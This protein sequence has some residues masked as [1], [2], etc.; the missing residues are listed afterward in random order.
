MLEAAGHEV[1]VGYASGDGSVVPNSQRLGLLGSNQ[2]RDRSFGHGEVTALIQHLQPDVV[3]LH[4]IQNLGAIQ[5]AVESGRAVLHG[6]DYRPICPASNFFYKRTKTICQRTC[7]PGCFAVTAVKHCMT[8]RPRPALYFYQRSRWVVQNAGRF[9]RVIAPS[10]GA[11]DRYLQAGFKPE[12]V[13]V[14]PYFCPL[15]PRPEPSLLTEVPTVTF[16]GRASYNKGW[17]VFVNALGQLPADVHGLMVGNF[18]EQSR[19]KI[20]RLAQSAGCA[21]RLAI[22]GWAGRDAIAGIYA[23]TTVFVFPSLWPETMGIVGVEALSQGVPVVASDVGGVREWLV[24]GVTGRLVPPN[25]PPAVAAALAECLGNPAWLA[26]AARAGIQL[27]QQKFA[28]A[29]H[30]ESLMEIYRKVSGKA[31][32]LLRS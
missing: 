26:E 32:T 12:Q 29:R 9:A 11:R 15:P 17:E 23:R 20:S 7:G 5:A 27:A 21:G 4:G 16:M 14:L 2:H 13:E 30:M 18:G 1:H 8:P 24:D 3:H 25:D 28:P 19:A 6:H 22:E 10:A 31:E